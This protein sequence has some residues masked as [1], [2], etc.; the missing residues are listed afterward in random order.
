MSEVSIVIPN[1]NGMGYLKDCLD[2]LEVQSM[3]DFETILVDNG[4][5]DESCLLYTSMYKNYHNHTDPYYN[6]NLDPESCI[7]RR[8]NGQKGIIL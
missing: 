2:S 4:S 3:R 7:P 5:E 1:Y 6:I 8:R